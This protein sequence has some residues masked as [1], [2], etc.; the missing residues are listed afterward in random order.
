MPHVAPRI[1]DLM[2][3][4]Y[5]CGHILAKL[6]LEAQGRDN[7]ELVRAMSGLS[8]GMGQGFNCASLSGG[9]GLLGLYGGSDSGDDR[10]R[11]R[12][13][14]MV[15]EFAGWFETEMIEKFGSINCEEIIEFDPAMKLKRCPGVIL[16]SWLKIK[17]ILAKNKIDVARPTG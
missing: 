1:A 9:C 11:K 6:A 14:I 13:D 2:R 3:H 12:V 10:A 15:E 16:A 4:E 5:R 8:L 7:P 17:E